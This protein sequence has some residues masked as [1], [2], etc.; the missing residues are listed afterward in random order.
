MIDDFFD[1]IKRVMDDYLQSFFKD[2]S[3]QRIVIIPKNFV[4]PEVDCLQYVEFV[5]TAHFSNRSVHDV[6]QTVSNTKPIG[7]CLEL[8]PYRY[9]YLLNICSYCLEKKGCSRKC[10]F[11]AAIETLEKANL[12]IWLIDMIQEEI[13]ARV[14]ARAS[15]EEAK[16][17]QRLQKYVMQREAYG[18]RLWEEGLKDEAMHLFDGDL[19]LMRKS[20]PTLWQVLILERNA[21]MSCRLI[22]LIS[23]YL[24][25]GLGSFK[26]IVFTGVAHVEGIREL[27]KRP[28]QAFQLL[29]QFG[30]A[31]SL[32]YMIRRI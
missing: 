17:W 18:L 23:Q 19:Y 26:I 1:E 15:S 22:Y 13:M 11:M 5:G 27:L 4:I 20:F 25:K 28:Q 24:D 2:S 29:D 16:S 10:E 6:I 31:F 30:I 8:C 9:E 14:L 7:I 3:T 32:P 12:D 21:L